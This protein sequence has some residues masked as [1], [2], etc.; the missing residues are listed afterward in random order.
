V[1]HAPA[2]DIR[3]LTFG[4][5]ETPVLE[6]VDLSIRVG[7]FVSLVGPNGGGKTT[8]LRLILGLLAPQRGTIRVLGCAPQDARRRIGYMP[9]R[10]Q[11]DPQFPVTVS[12]V[13]LMG[14]LGRGPR[15]GPFGA[16][17]RAAALAALQEVR[18]ADRARSA[19]SSLS[20]GQ[21]Q[22]VLIARALACDPEILMLDE[23]TANLDPR[24]QDDL[25]E[26]LRELNQRLTVIIVSHDVGFVSRYVK[27]VVCVNRHVEIHPSEK[28]SPEIMRTLY[29]HDVQEVHH[30][31]EH[32]DDH[33]HPHPHRH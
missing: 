4:Y 10:V 22:R 30:R 32:D 18:L 25:Y 17:D 19:F 9:Q 5:D 14:R 12:D 23:P 24:V 1:N 27:N 28:L 13:V 21:R 31:H 15:I 8:L 29:G 2:I 3:G 16:A 26:L 20:G 6:D 33:V 11:L 7:D